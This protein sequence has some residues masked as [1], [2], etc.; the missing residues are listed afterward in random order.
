M[1]G[2]N[3]ASNRYVRDVLWATSTRG[4]YPRGSKIGGKKVGIVGL[5]NIGAQRLEAFGLVQFE[6]RKAVFVIVDAGSD[7]FE[8]E[9]DVP[10]QLFALHHMYCTSLQQAVLT[11]EAFVGLAALVTGNLEAFFS[12]NRC[13]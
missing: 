5:G 1:R 11:H 6:E 10:K 12:N 13:T 9:P 2:K 7:V 3:S 8:N 4:D